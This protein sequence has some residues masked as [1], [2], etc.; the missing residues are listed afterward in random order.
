MIKRPIR[1]LEADPDITPPSGH[2]VN[3]RY[4]LSVNIPTRTNIHKPTENNKL[5]FNES[6]YV[7]LIHLNHSCI[8]R[9]LYLWS[10]IRA[11]FQ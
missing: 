2:G 5:H 10:M 11:L 8:S 7:C 1:G 3:V 4:G 6:L 9:S